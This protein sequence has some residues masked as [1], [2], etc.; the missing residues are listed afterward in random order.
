MAEHYGTAIIPA[1][2]RKPK[3]KA[4]VEGSVGVVSTWTLA[5]LRNQQF[6][7]LKEPNEA[8]REKLAVF[9]NK[10]IQKKEGSR[11]ELF[12]EEQL[13]LLPLPPAPFELFV[14]KVVTVQYRKLRGNKCVHLPQKRV[15]DEMADKEKA[16]LKETISASFR[17]TYCLGR[18]ISEL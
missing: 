2:P 4:F 14:W 15:L 3:D 7:S 17:T 12:W 8:I 10:P 11:A 18:F 5:A 9:N 13:F 6:L 16:V 1:R